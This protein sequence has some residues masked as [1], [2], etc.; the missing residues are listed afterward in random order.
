MN[1]VEN[2]ECCDEG[3]AE[4]T[5]SDE[6]WLTAVQLFQV[7]MFTQRDVSDMFQAIRVNVVGDQVVLTD[8]SRRQIEEQIQA[9]ADAAP[10]PM[11]VEQPP[12]LDD[13]APVFVIGKVD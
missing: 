9:L 1:E 4:Y 11:P 2:D 5:L 10:V 3:K 8:E 13:D 12:V 6:V 7:A